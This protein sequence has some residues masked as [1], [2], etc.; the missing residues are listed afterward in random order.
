[1]EIFKHESIYWTIHYNT[2][3]NCV[4]CRAKDNNDVPDEFFMSEMLLYADI[5]AQYQA[6]CLMLNLQKNIYIV[7][8]TVQ[9]WVER[10]VGVKVIAA[11]QKYVAIIL[12]E[13][14]IAN[15]GTEQLMEEGEIQKIT[16]RYFSNENEAFSWLSQQP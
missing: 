16:T 3:L 10:E 4:N 2:T 6:K 1:M 12:G 14:F 13:D 8:P 9:E 7:S 11:G 15:L 5:V